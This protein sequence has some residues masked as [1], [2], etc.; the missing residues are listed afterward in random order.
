MKIASI[1]GARPQFIKM[2]P[3]CRAFK[4]HQDLQH[5]IIHTDQHYDYNMSK[6][7][8]DELEIPSPDYHLEV[9]S[10]TH[11]YQTG[12]MIKRIEDVLIKE[13]PDWVVVY[14]DT[15]STLA[16]A[17][18]AAKT[19]IPVAHV[20]AGLRS[21]NKSMPEEINRVLTDH[22]AAL[23]FCPTET[24]IENLKKEGIT[25][26][27]HLVGDIMYDSVLYN[28]R[29]A[30]N[31]SHILED[32]HLKPRGY[33]LVTVHRA[34]N[35]DQSDRLKHIFSAL[36][37]IVLNG[38]KVI[39]PLHPRTRK[40]LE[41]LKVSFDNL[42]AI[43]PVSYLDMLVLEKQAKTI[44]TDSGGI[45]KEAFF[46]KVPCITLRRETEWVETVKSGWNVLV[47]TDEHKIVSCTKGFSSVSHSGKETFGDGRAAEKIQA[48][49]G[50]LM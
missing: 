9:G 39:V 3:L 45:Q 36:E 14:G 49:F 16:G 31:R 40:N 4:E 20:E 7:F 6:V 18:S 2:A 22:V 42:Q 37:K 21:F 34:E 46:F 41:A 11:G 1:I 24:A 44:I 48:V 27:I 8:F 47:D 10:G 23:L 50:C 19:S 35:T 30:E 12:E 33:V 17:L 28:V 32:L 43:E 38:M 15:N 13:S 26:G 25:Q 29:L 5:I